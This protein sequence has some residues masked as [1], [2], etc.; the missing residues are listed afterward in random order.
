MP[1]TLLYL[2]LT[3]F[4]VRFSS[5]EGRGCNNHRKTRNTL[6]STAMSDSI[7]GSKPRWD[8]SKVEMC[9]IHLVL[10]RPQGCFHVYGASR[11]VV[12]NLFSAMG[13]FDDLA[14]SCG[15]P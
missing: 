8:Q 3:P 7:A 12:P 1:E 10:G 2:F 11:A 9:K 13:P 6:L 4:R 15:P 14:E 5:G